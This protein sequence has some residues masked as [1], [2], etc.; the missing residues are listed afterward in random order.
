MTKR[1]LEIKTF[2]IAPINKKKSNNKKKGQAAET[3]T[4]QRG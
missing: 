1:E 4:L 3:D 2:W